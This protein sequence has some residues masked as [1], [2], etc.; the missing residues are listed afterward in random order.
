MWFHHDS[1]FER[2]V[3]DHVMLAVDRP[4]VTAPTAQIVAFQ[5][6][7]ST[8]MQPMQPNVAATGLAIYK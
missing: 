6:P 1:V 5:A 4:N 7:A 8:N 3:D 2:L